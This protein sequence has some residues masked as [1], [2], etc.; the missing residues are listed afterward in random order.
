MI[1]QGGHGSKLMAIIDMCSRLLLLVSSP[2]LPNIQSDR[3]TAIII[4]R[5]IIEP[6]PVE[7]FTLSIPIYIAAN[8]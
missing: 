6:S 1:T 4:V 2:I 5:Y 7:I 8:R 3:R